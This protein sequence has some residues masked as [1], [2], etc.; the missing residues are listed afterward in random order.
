MLRERGQARDAEELQADLPFCQR[1][2]AFALHPLLAVVIYRRLSTHSE[3]SLSGA[4][5]RWSSGGD[6]CRSC[7]PG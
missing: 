6:P 1:S 5:G 7:S 3:L 4:G 2:S